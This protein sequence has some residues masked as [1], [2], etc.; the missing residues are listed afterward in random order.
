MSYSSKL[1]ANSAK[2]NCSYKYI[3]KKL[4]SNSDTIRIIIMKRFFF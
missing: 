3:K 4:F 2:V 1:L